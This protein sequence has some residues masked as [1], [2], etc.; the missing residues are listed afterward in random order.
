MARWGI[1]PLGADVVDPTVGALVDRVRRAADV[2][3]RRIA[4]SPADLAGAA[5]SR[6]GEAI[7][8]FVAPAGAWPVFARLPVATFDGLRL[9]PTTG[10]DARLDP[11]WLEIVAPVR[12]A[13]GRLEAVQLAE[14]SA[15]GGRPMR[16]WSNRLGDPWQLVTAPPSDTAVVRASHLVAVFGPSGVMQS[17][18][19][20]MT[21]GTVAVAV[22]DRFS[23][24]VPDP[25]QV[26][27]IAFPHDLPPARAPQAVVLAVPPVVD[28]ELTPAVLVDIVAEVRALARVRMADTVGLGAATNSLHLAAMPSSGRVG[29]ELGAR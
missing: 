9:E 4:D 1:T 26:S 18:P 13:I 14:R 12:T 25:E 21:A 11:D 17:R 3:E 16:A 15:S 28:E 7:A 27:A 24:T 6:M 5:L 8:A 19:T 23:E 10:D 20:A 29:V 2:L 22:I